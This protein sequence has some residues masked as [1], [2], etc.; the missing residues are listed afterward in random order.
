V[1]DVSSAGV[2]DVKLMSVTGAVLY[3]KT[4]QPETTVADPCTVSLSVYNA[5]TDAKV[6]TVP[7]NGA[8]TNPPCN[9][10]IEVT[11]TCTP[12]FTY[13]SVFIEL[14]AGS[15][16]LKFRNETAA[17]Y[18]LFGNNGADVLAGSIP[19]GIYTIRSTAGGKT[20]QPSLLNM[21]SC[22]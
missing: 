10:N 15:R 9:V 7:S 22:A 8:V 14:M 5:V 17:P 20:F 3:S 4:L 13:N 1:A 6:S 21:G 11:L 12:P 2:L 18:F 19:A 16:V